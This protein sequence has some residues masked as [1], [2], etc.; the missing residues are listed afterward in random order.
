MT[1]KINDMRMFTLPQN[2][3]K[4]GPTMLSDKDYLNAQIANRISDK[5]E[6]YYTLHDCN[7]DFFQSKNY[8]E[9][10]EI[11][12]FGLGMPSTPSTLSFD[13]YFKSV[14]RK[15][16]F[17]LQS[18]LDSK[19]KSINAWEKNLSDE[20]TISNIYSEDLNRIKQVPPTSKGFMNQLLTKGISNVANIGI[21]YLDNV[22]TKLR[23]VR[24]GVVNDALRQF[25]N[26]TNINKI[27]PDNVYNKDFN[28]RISLRNFGKQVASSILNDLEDT[29][30][31][32]MNF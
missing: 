12:G 26:A 21:D 18:P 2:S 31:D 3:N 32:T 8:G 14:T 6:I 30:R 13:I 11:G 16:R 19:R 25:R 24:G 29:T 28:N 1:I 20:Q 7:F 15:S 4:S 23:E 22:E 5:S 27:E 17:P 10:L 9:G